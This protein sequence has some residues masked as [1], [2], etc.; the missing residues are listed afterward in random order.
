MVRCSIFYD[1]E[2]KEQFFMVRGD[3]RYARS[4]KT[5][6]EY[7]SAVDD[8]SHFDCTLSVNVL[9]DTGEG[10][11]VIYD[12]E[13]LTSVL[14]YD[15]TTSTY[16]EMDSIP[17]SSLLNGLTFK[18]ANLTYDVDH[19]FTAKYIGNKSCSPSNSSIV[20]VN[21][22]DLN[23]TEAVITVDST[24]QYDPSTTI[25]KTITLSND[26]LASY[27]EG[28]EI[29]VKYDDT[30]I[31]TV[32]TDENGQATVDIPSGD[33]ALHTITFDY[34][35]SS[36]LTSEI[37]TQ[38]VS[39]GYDLEIVSCPSVL[40]NQEATQCSIKV[41]DWFNNPI[42]NKTVTCKE[43]T[44]YTR[45]TGST[46][47]NGIA[48]FNITISYYADVV[49]THNLSFETENGLATTTVTV[50][51]PVQLA[52]SISPTPLTKGNTSVY[53]ALLFPPVENVPITLSGSYG[54]KLYTNSQ[55]VATYNAV[56]TGKGSKTF[57]VS[58]GNLSD[59]QTVDDYLQYWV[60]G[61]TPIN[62]DYSIRPSSVSLLD[63]SN[64]FQ[65][66]NIEEAPSSTYPYPMATL[67]MGSSIISNEA[68]DSW[69]LVLENVRFSK[70]GIIGFVPDNRYPHYTKGINATDTFTFKLV[71]EEGTFT[72]YENGTIVS[73][74]TVENWERY[75]VPPQVQFYN[76]TSNS[77]NVSFTKLTYR[78]L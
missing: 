14:V 50:V 39:V 31:D 65:I 48:T 36:H 58:V 75:V 16:V 18:V 11:I 40:I 23:R 37:V 60:A 54:Q 33:R 43:Y 64:Y 69:E 9:R 70:A 72:V 49:S 1:N 68:Y 5:I 8:V 67:Y 7:V 73:T 20:T 4:T 32:T 35:G 12:N 53:T 3:E 74:T 47:T 6:L 38:D 13:V 66:Y 76:P 56:G 24:V 30:V 26:L 21:R 15:E 59:S 42:S 29:V 44:S 71:K 52:T 63:L 51:Y 34:G 27:N 2:K 57:N 62:R 77:L 19:N 78:R 25:T 61:S 22:P 28:Q 41:T 10:S 46:G 55:G 17:W 45:G